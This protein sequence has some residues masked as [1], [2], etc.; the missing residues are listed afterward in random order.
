VAQSKALEFL[1]KSALTII[2]PG[3]EYTTNV[4]IA[5]VKTLSHDDSNSP[6]FSSD[7]HEFAGGRH[8]PLPPLNCH[9]VNE[10]LLNW[11]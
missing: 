5:N 8:G 11:L 10:I 7:G 2:F 4:I 9:W 1:Q 6:S 3:S